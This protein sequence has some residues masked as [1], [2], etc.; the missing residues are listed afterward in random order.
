MFNSRVVPRNKSLTYYCSFNM[1]F[2]NTV[3]AAVIFPIIIAIRMVI[4]HIWYVLTEL[5]NF[6]RNN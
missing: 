1:F 5:T 2:V 4:S 6:K 3:R